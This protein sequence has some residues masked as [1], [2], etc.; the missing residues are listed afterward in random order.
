MTSRIH[1]LREKVSEKEGSPVAYN[2]GGFYSACAVNRWA[3]DDQE[4][5]VGGNQDL[6]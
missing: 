5:Q 6:E 1:S 3:G 4:T 2:R